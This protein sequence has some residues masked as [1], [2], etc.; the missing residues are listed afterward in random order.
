MEGSNN[1]SITLQPDA[2]SALTFHSSSSKVSKC[3]AGVR[4]MFTSEDLHGRWKQ[5]KINSAKALPPSIKYTAVQCTNEKLGTQRGILYLVYNATSL[6]PVSTKY[7]KKK[8]TK[9]TDMGSK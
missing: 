8:T 9:R 2:G 3:V 1:D 7:A 5:R 6:L 4:Q